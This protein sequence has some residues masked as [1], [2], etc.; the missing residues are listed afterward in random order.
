MLFEKTAND[1]SELNLKENLLRGVFSYGFE[2]PS[3]IQQK[4]I[5]PI[6]E[7]HDTIA[8]ASSGSGKTA[9]FSIGAL[10]AV[11]VS[12]KACQVLIMAPTRELALQISGV[13]KAL[14]TFMEVSTY[15]CIGGIKLNMDELRRAQ[16]VVGTPGRVYDLIESRKLK[17]S[18]IKMFI[19]DEA[20]E[21][22]SQGFSDQISD[23]YKLL[24]NPR[25]QNVILSAT[26]SPE[27]LEIT[28]KFMQDPV[29]ILVKNEELTLEGIKQ[30]YVNIENENWKLDTL[31][32][33][34]DVVS[35]AQS[36]I[37]VNSKK[38]AEWLTENMISRDFTVACI[39][40]EMQQSDRQKTLSDFRSGSS[41]VLIATDILARG[42]DVQQVSLVINY[43]LPYKVETFIHRIGRS[44]RY[45][46]KGVCINFVT[47]DTMELQKNIE[48]YYS[49]KF[50]EMPMNVAE[51]L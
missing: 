42:I 8:Q 7:G 35:V 5:L 32:D 21:M 33:L 10:Q 37:F 26:M 48:K 40:G 11:D 25:L 24:E 44:A 19:L 20:D 6:I 45:G 38:K 28:E 47:S 17:S 36:V 23:I 46:R 9:T 31:C 39:H 13:V 27:V 15:T 3:A 14:S 2:K 41:R 29:R 1:F 34:F 43:D 12:L 16:I 30:F 51:Y 4:A 18:E 50:E 49:T 22:L